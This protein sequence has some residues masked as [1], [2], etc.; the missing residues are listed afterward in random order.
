MAVTNL[1][2][3]LNS[4]LLPYE[5]LIAAIVKQA[6]EDISDRSEPIRGREALYFIESEWFRVLTGIDSAYMI[7]ILEEE[8]IV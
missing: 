7:E 1:N 2:H 8:G 3:I 4:A 5:M 6:V